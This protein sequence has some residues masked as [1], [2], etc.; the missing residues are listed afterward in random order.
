MAI[1]IKLGDKDLPLSLAFLDFVGHVI[2]GTPPASG[3]QNQLDEHLSFNEVQIAA[4]AQ[5]VAKDVLAHPVGKRA[6]MRAYQLF[7]ALVTGQTE[8]LAPYRE[9]YRFLFVVGAPRHG[10]SYLIKQAY[11]ALGIDAD[12]V[13]D[14]IAHDGF[15]DARPFVLR[16][17]FNAFSLMMRATAEYLTMLDLYFEQAPAHPGPVT[18][19]KKATKFA[20]QGSFFRE[21]FGP[22]ADYLITLRHP[23]AACISTYEKSGGLPADGKFCVRS[24][25]EDWAQ[26]SI[27]AMD[28]RP[29]PH[30]DYFT[31]YLHYWE[32]YH[33]SLATTGLL[34][35]RQGRVVVYGSERMMSAAATLY[36]QCGSELAPEVFHTF[37]KRDRHADWQPRA[38]AAIRRV[39]VAWHWAGIPFPVEELMEQW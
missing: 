4:N 31:A 9:K 24:K 3:W 27:E 12:T 30:D 20:Y 35:N 36:R 38:L 19:P 16:P 2:A 10:G 34:A 13:P 32:H 11:R 18:V 22:G 15:P 37:D 8:R 39:Q 26:M 21:V 23:I 28:C 33:M 6:V 7:V 1:Q 14:V 29:R 17:Q 25:I 5:A